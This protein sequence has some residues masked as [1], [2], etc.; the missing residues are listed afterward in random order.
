MC[1]I[2]GLWAPDL[3]PE[4]RAELV[5]E[6]VARLAHRGPDGVALWSDREVTI[7]IA[8]LAIVDP[9]SPARVLASED[10]R[11][12]AVA[13]GE[14]YNHLELARG[15]VA[16]GHRVPPGPDTAVVVNLYEQHG[17]DF[18]RQLEGMFAL[19]IWDSE[20]RQLVLA[21][22]RAG[23]KPL[24][25]AVHG[26]RVAFASEPAALLTLPWLVRQPAPGAVLRYLV[27]GFFA[28]P[29]CAFEGM[30]QVAPGSVVECDARG[31]R[32]RHYWR[33]WDGLASAPARAD[34]PSLVRT[35]R[36]EL[37]RAVALRI[38]AEMPFGVFLS[39]GLDS[40][41]IAAA[42]ARSSKG[43]PTFS[44]ALTGHGYDESAFAREVARHLGTQHH[45]VVMDHAEGHEA[46]QALAATMD[47]PL[48][49]PSMIPT[50]YLARFASRHVPVVLTGEGGDELFAGYPTYLGHRHAVLLNRLPG[51]LSDSILAFARR[52]RPADRH[53][54]LPYFVERFLSARGLAPFDRHLAWFGNFSP[55][56]ART[57]L[58]PSLAERATPEDARGHI[59]QLRQE[60]DPA[61]LLRLAD[62]PGLV[63][64]QVFDFLLTLGGGLLT[65][66]DRSTM[67][68]SVESRAPFLG[69][70]MIAW[71]LSLPDE[72]KLRGATGKWILKQVAKEWLPA[73]VITRRKQGFSPPFSA[74]VRGPWRDLVREMLSP[75]RIARAGVLDGA[76]VSAVL[77]RHLR[78]EAESGRALWS[79][80]SLQLWAERWL[81]DP[82]APPAHLPPSRGAR[83]QQLATEEA[84]AARN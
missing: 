58:H 49:D 28:A 78:N 77:E 40:S 66:V 53:L 74:W 52:A 84:P 5:A 17:I 73:P 2:A 83:E 70:D 8:R 80:L 71:A 37:E 76:R 27:H 9:D 20:R 22:D 31:M 62:R 35:T 65:K 30:R 63:G 4:H 25:T 24:F 26:E 32:A 29:D 21:R 67:A 14:I 48:G 59:Q 19:A 79:L 44:L 12:H 47:Q 75:A 39:G 64:Y 34:V 61:G 82:I 36:L 54:S 18:P 3:A 72:V 1:G 68:H 23:E 42:A 13:N 57:L 15:I 33:P 46:L 69:T 50:W 60:L 43:F 45:E 10:G 6:M 38:P 51:A 41:L 7:G 55:E 11:I 56:E 81:L 16:A